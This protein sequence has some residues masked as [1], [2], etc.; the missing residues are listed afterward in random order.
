MNVRVVIF[1][2]ALISIALTAIAGYLY[3]HSAQESAVT[4]VQKQV[5]ET[6]ERLKDEVS[7]HV[8]DN[9]NEVRALAQF[10]ELRDALQNPKE[11]MLANANRVMDHFAVGLA[12]DV[13]F[14][15]DSSGLCIA[16]SNRNKPDSFVGHDYSFRAYFQDAIR[17]SPS[18]ELALGV[19]T[20]VRGIFFSHP[21]YAEDGPTPVG[22]VA[23]KVSIGS[24]DRAFLR[25]RN[26][27]SCLVHDSGMIFASSQPGWVMNFLWKAS[28]EELTSVAKTRQ[29]GKGPWKW[30]GF[31][32]TDG[33][34]AL[35]SSGEDY[36]LKETTIDNS[37]GWRLVLLYRPKLMSAYIGAPLIRDAGYIAVIMFFVVGIA[38]VVLYL[39]AQRDITERKYAE[40]E[41]R[42]SEERF[43]KAFENNP[44]WL[45]IVHMGTYK[46]VEVNDAWTK[47]FG[48]TR[49]EAIGKTTV[50][51]G[52]Y[53]EQTYRK[54]MEEARSTGS[55]ANTEVTVVNRAGE[56]RVL[57]VSR[58]LLELAGES[59]LLA[60]GIDI[61]DRKRADEALRRSEERYRTVADFTHDWETWVGL[62]DEFLYISPSCERIT[63]YSAEEFLRDPNL[64]NRIIHPE[65]QSRVMDHFHVSRRVRF[66]ETYSLDFRII[67]RTGQ[68]RWIGHICQ[69]VWSSDGKPLGRRAGNRDIT[70]RKNLEAQLLQAQKMEAIGTL[71]GG[72][73]H[74]FNNLLQVISGYSQILMADKQQTNRARAWFEKI[75]QAGKR[76]ADLVQNL[77]MFSR[78]VEPTLRPLNLNDEIVQ[79]R[80][81]LSRTIPKTIKIDLLLSDELGRV[82]ADASQLG[83]VLMNLALNARDAMPDGGTLTIE[84]S[85]IHLDEIYSSTDP[86]VKPGH[87]A[88]VSVSDTGHGM[89]RETLFRIFEP[90]FT[91]K[92]VG[93]GTGL[94]LSSA[95]GIIKQHD[96]Y[97]S[98]YSEPNHGTTFKIYLP[99]IDPQPE[100]EGTPTETGIQGGTE[101][102]LLV[103]DEE[104]LRDLGRDA[105]ADWGYHILTA[106]DGREALEI[107]RK[108]REEISLIILDL[109]MPE[110]DGRRCLAEI[111]KIDP[112]AK[113][114]IVSGYAENGPIPEAQLVG[115][116][117][118]VEKP[119]DMRKLLQ[120]VR[121]ILDG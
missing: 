15:I 60:M 24:V 5:F 55:V 110:M 43:S 9:Q 61:T 109:I 90:F 87:Y 2:F 81:L 7:D 92:E 49:E 119:Y 100:S 32:R 47:V 6:S 111:L 20:G 46:V 89:D 25:T 114:L 63:G 105:L 121:E 27:I 117:G 17:G 37:P 76:G 78:K 68:I 95:Y 107:Y 48:Y 36:V 1:L 94:G 64:M 40:D 23:I 45:A 79:V 77:L 71:A 85:N 98:C 84:T 66:S 13:C 21:I 51:L 65:D 106:A 54:I 83:Q 39:L 74:D 14:L 42:H 112:H 88:L 115:A 53:A 35:D 104:M 4:E 16:S 67:N 44:A 19:V 33:G 56:N 50:E 12:Y 120:I 22:V 113:V 41:L 69:P 75:Y 18:T 10:E 8:G 28:P 34:K 59:H 57:L 97:I 108:E 52:I 11:S 62:E 3:Y 103:D 73:A 93:K 26:M 99:A 58:E 29:F 30:T 82:Q 70:D 91:T 116:R 118:F 102:I 80:D 72:V 86:E 38:V 101:R 96:G 31:T